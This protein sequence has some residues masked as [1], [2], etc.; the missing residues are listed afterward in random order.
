M[1]MPAT[2]PDD[3]TLSALLDGDVDANAQ[4]HVAGCEAC[5]NR[6]A[7]LRAASAAVGQVAPA[8]PGVK[9]AAIRAAMTE[10]AL[11]A[12]KP[13]TLDAARR[14]RERRTR[15]PLASLRW[16]GAAAAIVAVLAAIPLLSHGSSSEKSASGTTAATTGIAG[17]TPNAEAGAIPTTSPTGAPAFGT[18]TPGGIA[19]HATA[20]VGDLGRQSATSTL[21][22]ALQS[23]LALYGVGGAPATS[24]L[25]L[26]PPDAT[27]ART[28]QRCVASAAAGSTGTSQH[29][30]A[31]AAPVYVAQ[32][33]WRGT[34][35]NVYVFT[36]STGRVAVVTSQS[37]C[38]VLL[39]FAF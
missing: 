5:T 9:E 27:E 25:P 29:V 4:A 36:T 17:A 6:L 20:N 1:N 16:V 12:A 37:T 31:T 39:A 7:R 22:A 32:L 14:K 33:E 23:Q 21:A 30:P 35:A 2:H 18:S 8:P 3:E 10:A 19:G 38:Q 28:L 24:Q 13:S 26:T 11:T 15:M 34:A